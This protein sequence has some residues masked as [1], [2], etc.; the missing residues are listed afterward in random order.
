[1]INYH[2]VLAIHE[3]LLAEFGGKAGVRDE[4]LLHSALE[5]PFMGFG[6][7]EFYLEPE[8]KAAAILESIIQNHP[9]IDGNK[10]TGYTLMRLLLM[11]YGKDIQGSQSEKYEFV[12]NVAS[13]KY[14]YTQ[15][16]SWIQR[17]V[18]AFP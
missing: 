4:G 3:V 11:Q 13:G 7:R 12:I 9:F 10:R 5:R 14:D 17:H 1:M 18:T 15:I 16:V 2:E 8:E 6:E